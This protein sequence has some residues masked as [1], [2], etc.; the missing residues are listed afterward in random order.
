MKHW[1]ERTPIRFI[2]RNENNAA[3]YPNYVSF[4]QYVP[5]PDER[6]EEIFHCSSPVGMQ[7]WGEQSI[8]LWD[9]CVTGDVIH[10][11]GHTVGLWHEQS[12]EDRN[13]RR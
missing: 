11:I 5:Q 10:E 3:L 8:I 2:Q 4:I 1:E 9:K 12:R 6:Q 13:K 7:N